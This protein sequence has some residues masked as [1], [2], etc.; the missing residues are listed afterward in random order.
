MGASPRRRDDRAI[1]PQPGRLAQ[2]PLQPG[3]RTEL[4]EQPDLAD[5]HRPRVDR[6][7]AE[8]RGEGERDGQIEARLGDAQAAGEVA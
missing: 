1:E 2:P 6:P 7:V 4:A 5:R 8:R 3:D